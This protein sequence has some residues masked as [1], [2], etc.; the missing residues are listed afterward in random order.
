M[1][2]FSFHHSQMAIIKLYFFSILQTQISNSLLNTSMRMLPI[3][4]LQTK[5]IPKSLMGIPKAALA[6]TSAPCIP[7]IPITPSINTS[8]NKS[9]SHNFPLCCCFFTLPNDYILSIFHERAL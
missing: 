5:R 3:Q 6:P 4:G 8:N 9:V 1:A 7:L 2:V